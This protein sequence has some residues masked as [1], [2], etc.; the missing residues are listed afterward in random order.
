VAP[1]ATAQKSPFRGAPKKLPTKQSP[2]FWAEFYLVSREWSVG[3][4]NRTGGTAGRHG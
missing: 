2:T 4:Q 1:L 3:R